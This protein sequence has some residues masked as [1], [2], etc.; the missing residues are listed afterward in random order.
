LIILFNPV[1]Y[2]TDCNGDCTVEITLTV[3]IDTIYQPVNIKATSSEDGMIYLVPVD[4]D[5][6][7]GVIRGACIDSVIAVMNTPVTIPLEGMENGTYWLYATDT[8]GS[9]SEPEAFTVMGC[10]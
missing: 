1:C 8:T 9:I 3:S 7:M 10:G 6:D 2:Q 4:T 5:K